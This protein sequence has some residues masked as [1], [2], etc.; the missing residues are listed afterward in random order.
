MTHEPASCGSDLWLYFDHDLGSN[1][2]YLLCPTAMTFYYEL[3]NRATPVTPFYVAC[4]N[5]YVTWWEV[6]IG[7]WG[8]VW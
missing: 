4:D 8:P 2:N 3:L 5:F 7:V 1:P 6:L